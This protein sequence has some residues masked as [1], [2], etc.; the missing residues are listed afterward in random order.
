MDLQCRRLSLFKRNGQKFQFN[1]PCLAMYSR[2]RLAIPNMTPET[3]EYL[4]KETTSL[5][6]FFV[7][8]RFFYSNKSAQRTV[9]RINIQDDFHPYLQKGVSIVSVYDPADTSWRVKL[10]HSD[11]HI[12]T[13][14]DG[15][16][17][18]LTP[19]T[20]MNLIDLWKPDY[21]ASLAEP[22][23]IEKSDKIAMRASK[24]SLQFL[25]TCIALNKV[26]TF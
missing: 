4:P 6:N 23:N 13:R 18:P 3:L 16:L 20:Y 24:R 8:K 14:T 26:L 7:E 2:R 5:F 11:K 19:E 25:D 21:F 1:T 17:I 12:I 10:D 22:P 9:S 15:G